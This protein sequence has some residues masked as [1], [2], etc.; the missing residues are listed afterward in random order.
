MKISP[1]AGIDPTFVEQGTA[2]YEKVTDFLTGKHYDFTA[3]MPED[4]D[5]EEAEDYYN[6]LPEGIIDDYGDLS[7]V[8]AVATV[9]G[10]VYIDTDRGDSIPIV[11]IN[12]VDLCHLCDLIIDGYNYTKYCEKV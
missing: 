2:L 8:I 5:R 6:T 9:E 3:D 10:N 1:N 11:Q 12:L 7:H 4:I